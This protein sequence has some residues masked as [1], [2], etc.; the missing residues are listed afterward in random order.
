MFETRV[1]RIGTKSRRSGVRRYTGLT[2]IATLAAAITLALAGGA[3]AIVAGAGFTTNDPNKNGDDSCLNGPASSTPKVNCN[4]YGSKDF[5]WINGGPTGGQNSLTDGTYFFAVLDPGGQK[6]PND[7]TDGNLSDAS[8][9]TNTPGGDA[10]TDREFTVSGGKIATYLGGGH[11]TDA[12]YTDPNGLFINLMP[13]D[14]TTNPGGVYIL[15]ICQ[16]STDQAVAPITGTVTPSSC[17]YDAFKAPSSTCEEDCTPTPFGGLSGLKY[18][19]ANA[20]G[21]LD[22]TE[23]GIPGWK[24]NIQDGFNQNLTTDSQGQF[25]IANIAPDTYTLTELQP[26]NQKCVTEVI[27]GVSTLVCSPIWKQSGNIVDQSSAPAGSSVAL[28]NFIYTVVLGDTGT[29]SGLNFG[30]LC[31]GAGG[32]LTLGYWSNKNGQAAQFSNAKAAAT[33]A[34]LDALNLRNANGSPF[35]PTTYAQ[36]RTWLLGASAT[37]MAYMLSA[38]LAAM[39]LNVRNGNVSG[40]SLVYAPGTTS[41]NSSGYATIDALMAEANTELGLHPL[42]TS[43]SPYRAYQEA[44]KTAL[45]R[46][47]NNLNFVQ[48]SQAGCPTPTFAAGS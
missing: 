32:G 25:S 14:D 13:Y 39:E 15:A 20:N 7:G 9:T 17:K 11:D 28:A 3:N 34:F 40:S 27:N 46:A 24:I 21:Q 22:G 41:A 37:N 6:D 45:D 43:G 5:V 36:F 1:P 38:Q 4:L 19:D 23:A 29:V 18:Y 33:L 30:N 31:L 42:T 16:L 8:P 47:N 48:S 44:L 35:D 10:Y 2:V 26:T 12:F